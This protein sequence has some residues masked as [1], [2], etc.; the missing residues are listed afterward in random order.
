MAI[1][2]TPVSPRRAPGDQRSSRVFGGLAPIEHLPPRAVRSYDARGAR[3]DCL[4]GE[5]WVTGPGI[6]DEVLGRGASLY[7]ARPGKIVIEALV[8]ARVRV[9]VS[10]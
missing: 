5:I 2:T 7:I 1:Q 9:A 3:I 10:R 4:E 6:G 8:S